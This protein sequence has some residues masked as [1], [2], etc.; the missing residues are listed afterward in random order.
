MHQTQPFRELELECRAPVS[1]SWVLF[2]FISFKN[3]VSNCGLHNGHTEFKQ[4]CAELPVVM[5]A[6]TWWSSWYNLQHFNNRSI[7]PEQQATQPWTDATQRPFLGVDFHITCVKGKSYYNKNWHCCV[8]VWASMPAAP[9]SR[10]SSRDKHQMQSACSQIL[11]TYTLPGVEGG[12][13]TWN[14]KRCMHIHRTKE[15]A[16]LAPWQP[17]QTDRLFLSILSTHSLTCTSPLSA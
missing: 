8:T 7:L 9:S 5:P 16:D 14:R 2:H 6:R 4:V 13:R 17:Q 12:I 10:I 11:L 1:Q 3:Q 15:H